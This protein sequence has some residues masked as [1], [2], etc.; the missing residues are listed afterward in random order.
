M[1]TTTLT[2]ELPNVAAGPDPLSLSDLA[3][4]HD[5]VV[6]LFQR[7]YYCGNCRTQVQ[8]IAER[9]DEFA[10]L[11]AEVVSILPEA[12]DRTR[13]WQEKYGLPFP[14]LADEDAAVADQYDQ[15]TRFGVLGQLHDLIGRMPETVVLD[16][17][18]GDATIY[19]RQKGSSPGD[20]PSVD[21]LLD[22]IRDLTE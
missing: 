1:S 11:D 5:A 16:T 6:L 7:D 22:A 19:E 14:L 17:R 21:E 4:E 18:E 13:A 20:R 15:P 3:S 10:A 8:A 9:Y 2:F 12:R